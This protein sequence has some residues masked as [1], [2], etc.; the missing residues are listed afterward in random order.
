M[1]KEIRLCASLSKP[2]INAKF[3]QR[4]NVNTDYNALSNKP[5]I[6]DVELIG[7]LTLADLSIIKE[8]TTEYWDSQIDYI[9]KAGELIVYTDYSEDGPALKVGDGLAYVVDLPFISGSGSSPEI[10]EM[11]LEHI[12][13][14]VVHITDS[15]R[16]S[17]NSKVTCYTVGE[18]LVFDS[19]YAVPDSASGNSF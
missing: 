12:A 13:N 11:L 5:S 3:D 8:G 2:E 16:T 4:V 14:N 6:N 9:P 10:L 1:I 7:N 19:D 18:L 15:E 17:W